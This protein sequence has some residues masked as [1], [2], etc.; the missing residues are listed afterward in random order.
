MSCDNNI[1]LIT[2]ANRVADILS[3]S[4][5][6]HDDPRITNAVLT[7]PSIRG[8]F[9]LDN[10]AKRVFCGVVQDCGLEAPE[11]KDWLD[12]PRYPDA[13][14][15]SYD[16]AGETKYKWSTDTEVVPGKTLLPTPTAT[17][18]I[19]VSYIEDGQNKVRWEPV[20]TI[21]GDATPT[22]TDATVI[23]AGGL[24]QKT[25][26]NG[27]ESVSDLAS[28]TAPFQGMKIHVKSYRA[29]ENLGG[30]DFVWEAT[31][32][33]NLHNGGYIIDPA[34]TAPTDW[35]DQ[36]Q[37]EAWF[38]PVG[39]VGVGCWVRQD[40]VSE[41]IHDFGALPD[42][43][44][45]VN[46][47]MEK[48]ADLG[49]PVQLSKG[50]YRVEDFTRQLRGAGNLNQ[51]SIRIYGVKTYGSTDQKYGWG[52]GAVIQ[53]EGDMFK[54]I[55]N[56]R[57]DNILLRNTP[58]KPY[59]KILTLGGYAQAEISN[60]VFGPCNY[61]IYNPG[62]GM[63]GY[64]VKPSYRNCMFYGAKEWS[65]YFEGVVANYRE[66]N[67][68]TSTNKRGMYIACPMTASLES[69]V[70]EYNEDGAITLD[71]YGYST[72]YSFNMKDIFFETNGAGVPGSGVK[73]LPH[74]QI[75]SLDEGT[76]APKID[77][78]NLNFKQENCYYTDTSSGP[79][80]ESNIFV[81]SKTVNIVEVQCWTERSLAEG[82]LMYSGSL[83]TKV[84]VRKQYPDTKVSII[85]IGKE[86]RAKDF[87]TTTATPLKVVQGNTV[88]AGSA[89]LV[90]Y[91]KQVVSATAPVTYSLAGASTGINGR[92]YVSVGNAH[93]EYTL[94]G[95]SGL[96]V[97]VTQVSMV[98]N[99]EPT[100]IEVEYVGYPDLTFIVKTLSTT[101]KF[102]HVSFIGSV[103][104]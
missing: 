12:R 103:G 68:Y 21:V 70:Y 38:Y 20:D 86:I 84:D 1:P 78:A 49:L 93:A 23:T 10:A 85:T 89:C 92:L 80:A 29:G 90:G 56:M 102:C 25:L 75:K 2:L 40:G 41:D 4:Y 64:N 14:L 34:A 83:A 11:G 100:Y 46:L 47:I 22:V 54:A 30:G 99:T 15:V 81:Y 74:V 72:T 104:I 44:D 43:V 63:E 6:D 28:I 66:E 61:H 45:K 31:T 27:L 53:G 24:N 7:A 37:L 65:R 57:L 98:G 88:V 3:V 32:N 50:V 35:G 9:L 97:N 62:K 55:V 39:A 51:K 77:A 26:N 76:G 60:C 59:G 67:C 87:I 52:S 71:L 36:A 91:D 73:S 42:G 79:K 96:G 16:D 13:L 69:C 8:E 19:A 48:M 33:K 101:G 58:D 95:N 17:G 5:V 82:T 18:T 94:T